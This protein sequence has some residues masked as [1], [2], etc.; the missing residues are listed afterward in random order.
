MY[1][2]VTCEPFIYPILS[3]Q[4]AFTAFMI[5]KYVKRDTVATFN[6][7]GLTQSHEQKE[8]DKILSRSLASYKELANE[9]LALPLCCHNFRNQ[10]NT[11]IN[12]LCLCQ[13]IWSMLQWQ[14]ELSIES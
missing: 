3:S 14:K 6:K 5:T 9:R 8:K 13:C 1:G 10:V 7:N 11:A 4:C 2:K 12:W